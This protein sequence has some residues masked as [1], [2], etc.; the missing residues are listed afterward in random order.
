[1]RSRTSRG[2]SKCSRRKDSYIGR[3][4]SDIVKVPSDSGIF[5]STGELQEFTGG[6]IGPHGPSGG[7]EEAGQGEARAPPSPNRIGLGGGSPPFLLFFLSFLLLL[8]GLGK[9][10][11]YSYL[12]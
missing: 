2:V 1:M 7:R 3:L 9:G 4:Y 5:R 8:I 12:E 6:S 10:G 11:V